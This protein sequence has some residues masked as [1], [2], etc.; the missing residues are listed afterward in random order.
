M[1]HTLL[2][3]YDSPEFIA[4]NIYGLRYLVLKK[5]GFKNPSLWQRLNWNIKNILKSIYYFGSVNLFI[6]KLDI[7]LSWGESIFSTEK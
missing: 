4:C 5:L 2:T 7:N 6:T 1:M 3:L